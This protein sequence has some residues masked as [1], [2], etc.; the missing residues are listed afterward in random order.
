MINT[1][2][3]D[4]PKTPKLPMLMVSDNGCIVLMES[5]SG[6]KGKG[7]VL[8]SGNTFHTSGY[9]LD[10]WSMSLFTPYYGKVTIENT[11]E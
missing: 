3:E 7:I 5:Q 1:H 8:S 9:T 4:E 10:S 2:V 6:N 11:L